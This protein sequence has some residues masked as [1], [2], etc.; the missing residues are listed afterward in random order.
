MDFL[1]NCFPCFF[2]F[3]PAGLLPSTR[4]RTMLP[5][6]LL[7]RR[8]HPV[9]A[10]EQPIVPLKTPV[11]IIRQPVKVSVVQGGV[12]VEMN[13]DEEL[14]AFD[15]TDE[16]VTL[17]SKRGLLDTISMDLLDDA[18]RKK[19]ASLRLSLLKISRDLVKTGARD[20]PDHF[21]AYVRI[22]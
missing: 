22:P 4:V 5:R 8:A 17:L 13:E 6:L 15:Y 14:K 1:Q 7:I 18:V 11:T 9:A 2:S 12:Y 21:F 3:P 16:A 20:K 19:G 10:Q